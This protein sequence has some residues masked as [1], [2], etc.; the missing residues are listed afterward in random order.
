[1]E[2]YR[3]EKHL[4]RPFHQIPH[5]GTGSFLPAPAAASPPFL[6]WCWLIERPTLLSHD[7]FIFIGTFVAYLICWLVN[8]YPVQKIFPTQLKRDYKILWTETESY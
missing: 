2:Y 6:N 8:S 3:V 4:L 1:M 5:W 7:Y